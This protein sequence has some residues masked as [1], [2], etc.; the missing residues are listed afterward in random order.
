MIHVTKLNNEQ[1]IVNCDLIELIEITPDTLLTLTTGRK[2]M[3][4]ESS[5]DIIKR[6]VAYRKQTG[7]RLAHPSMLAAASTSSHKKDESAPEEEDQERPKPGFLG[8]GAR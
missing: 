7:L 3:I 5:E 4:R 1:C 8:F 2:L 6:I